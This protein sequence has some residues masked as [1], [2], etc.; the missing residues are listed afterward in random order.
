[1]WRLAGA[2]IALALIVLALSAFAF[3]ASAVDAVV[4]EPAKWAKKKRGCAVPQPP[5]PLFKT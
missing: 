4:R 5:P 3:L 1:M 2:T